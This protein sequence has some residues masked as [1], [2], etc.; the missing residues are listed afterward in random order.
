MLHCIVS[1]PIV[2]DFHVRESLALLECRNVVE[3]AG[4]FF[5][6]EFDFRVLLWWSQA[7]SAGLHDRSG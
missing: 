5:L 2:Y 4:M 1:T 6:H 3:K 7:S